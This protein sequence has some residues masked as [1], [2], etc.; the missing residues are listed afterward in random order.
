MDYEAVRSAIHE[1]GPEGAARFLADVRIIADEGS[2]VLIR[3]VSDAGR[4]WLDENV[5]SE[6]Y[7]WLGGNLAIEHGYAD[8]LLAAMEEAGL[9]VA[10]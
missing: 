7:Q 3:P 10:S 8:G 5:E 4:E 1:R 6:S 9:G 2:V